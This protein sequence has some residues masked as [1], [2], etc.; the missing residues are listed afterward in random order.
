[1]ILAEIACI[2]MAAT[3]VQNTRMVNTSGW[4]MKNQKNFCANCGREL[5][6]SEHLF[7]ADLCWNCFVGLQ[8]LKLG[9]K[10]YW[11]SLGIDWEA[12]SAGYMGA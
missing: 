12:N 7:E 6:P 1:M 2:A 3:P 11:L 5:T 4:N 9:R 8:A 10:I